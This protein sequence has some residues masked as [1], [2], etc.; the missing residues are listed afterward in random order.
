VYDALLAMTKNDVDKIYL[1]KC[2]EGND[3]VP[4]PLQVFAKDGIFQ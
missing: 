4:Q 3:I 1:F 2:R